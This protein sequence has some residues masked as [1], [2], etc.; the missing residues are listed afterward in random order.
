MGKD[1]CIAAGRPGE[2]N[3]EPIYPEVCPHSCQPIVL[4]TAVAAAA[5][6]TIP[7]AAL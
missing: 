3:R 7:L 4:E 1:P 6:R 2:S 5:P